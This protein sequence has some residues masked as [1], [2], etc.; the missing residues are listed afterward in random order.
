[1]LLKRLFTLNTQQKT[2]YIKISHPIFFVHGGGPS[3]LTGLGYYRKKFLELGIASNHL[4]ELKYSYKESFAFAVAQISSQI[5][6]YL[7]A[8]PENSK[9]DLIAYSMGTAVSLRAIWESDLPISKYFSIAGVEFGQIKKPWIC[10]ISR[11]SDAYDIL[12]PF[13]NDWIIKQH[14]I[15]ATKLASFEKVAIHSPKD[16]M[17]APYNANIFEDGQIFEIQNHSHIKLGR[18]SEVFNILKTE[19]LKTTI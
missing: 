10:K 5:I 1:M 11:C 18:S 12:T 3:N 9:F 8:Y 6:E 13:K 19:L 17:L 2:N 4:I 15:H 14:K 7:A 16:G